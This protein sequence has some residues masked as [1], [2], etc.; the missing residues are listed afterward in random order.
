MPL[1]IVTLNRFNGHLSLSLIVTKVKKV[2]LMQ[3][4][5]RLNLLLG[6]HADLEYWIKVLSASEV[7]TYLQQKNII[8]SILPG[9]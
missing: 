9:L 2:C 5:F 4:N 8:A 6:Q 1:Q 3:L 7:I